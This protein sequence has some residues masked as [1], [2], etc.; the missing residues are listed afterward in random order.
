[1]KTP[2]PLKDLDKILDKCKER[3]SRHYENGE[4]ERFSQ[5]ITGTSGEILLSPLWQAYINELVGKDFIQIAYD[6]DGGIDGYISTVK[7]LVFIGFVNAYIEEEQKPKREKKRFIINIVFIVAS[8]LLSG[9][10]TFYLTTYQLREPSKPVFLPPIQI[11][12][13][14]VYLKKPLTN[15]IEI[16]PVSKLH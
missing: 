13:D 3:L 4:W 1:M 14:T 15:T 8:S 9:L 6:K 10:I 16:R 11:I 7:G 2:K 12:H 5:L